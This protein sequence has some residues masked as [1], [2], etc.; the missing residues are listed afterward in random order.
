MIQTQRIQR[1]NDRSV[2]TGRYVLYWMQA[3]QRA[4]WNHALEHAI[5][6]ANELRQPLLAV[7]G[8]TD[9]YPEASERHYAFMLE[10]LRETQQ[11]LRDRGVRL[12]VRRESP[13]AAAL[14]MAADASLL[15]TDR[16][17]TRHQKAWREHVAAQ[18]PCPVVQVESDVVV[19]VE[20]ASGK[21]E[22]SAATLRPRIHRQLARFLVPLERTKLHRDS[23]DM[24]VES[25]PIDDVDGLLAEL[26]IDRSA[27]R[28]RAFIGGASQA[29]RLLAE[30][31]LRNLR[32]YADERN[33]PSRDIQSHQ[34]P[35]LHFGQVS[36]LEIALR[37]REARAPAAAK[38]AY[39]EELIVRRE[40]A[41]NYVHHSPRYDSY[42]SLPDWAKRT[43]ADHAA[44][45]RPAL[46]NASQLERAAT[47]DP[48]WN[49]SMR[50]MLATGKMHNYMRM[51]WGKKVIEWTRDPRRAFRVLL[52]LNNK[53][54]LDGRDPAGWMNVAWCFGLHDR[55]WKERPVFGKVRYMGATGLER[56]FD[57]DAYVRWAEM[58]QTRDSS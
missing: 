10:G 2:Q 43:L 3:S 8:L 39:L 26:R 21:R 40:L 6:Q 41:I 51:Y 12:V 38:E 56:K 48:Y 1:L 14:R 18:A 17:Y 55:P 4:D 33:D 37:V 22:Y 35:Y 15:V 30:F 34:S 29:D 36:P 7:F 20:T 53:Y 52:A 11:A 42:D 45:A 19:P 46:Y 47:A 58:L 44:D 27:G 32:R 16:G 28:V 50:E 57:I 13:E 9:D 54:F 5:R 31:L 49:A 24:R 25:Q 23:L